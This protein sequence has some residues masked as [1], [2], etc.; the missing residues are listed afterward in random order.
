MK[1][2]KIVLLIVFFAVLLT[3]LFPQNIYLLV[4]FS[5]LTWILLPYKQWWDGAGI[6]LL[7]FSIFY[8]A[9][10]ILSGQV[11]S[12]F[13][14]ISYLI[15]P[16]A[17]YRF[18]R[19]LMTEYRTDNVRFRLLLFM[20]YAYLLNVFVLTAVDISVVG[21]INEDRM[22]LG[23]STSDDALAA[24]LYGLMTSVGIGCIGACFAKGQ[25]I[26]VRF[27]YFILVILSLLTVIHLVNRG[28]LVILIMC[29]ATSLLINYRRSVVKLVL[30]IIAL[31]IGAF[32]LLKFG[33]LNG[34]VLD[35]YEERNVV[36]GYG[37]ETAGGRT[38]LWLRSIRNL[39]RHPM[40]WQQ[41]FYAHNLW[42]DVARIGGWMSLIPFLVSTFAILYRQMYL[43]RRR[44]SQFIL[45][46][47]VLNMALLLAAFI[48]PVI[49]GSMS[50]FSILIL[51]WGMTASLYVESSSLN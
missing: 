39:L 22:L 8:A 50:F 21:I 9:M 10:V 28:G 17:F 4:L 30:V 18:G 48:E 27:L 24:T 46:L 12:G 26:F 35:A 43:V 49:E 31:A 42:I 23:T 16:V 47:A 20:A 25:K 7:L 34:E 45:A 36:G 32:L 29:L 3:S 33:L 1:F 2:R 15:S 13:L 6:A 11:K 37:V 51:I 5:A 19:Y 40:G 38:D 14:T 44:N 41:E